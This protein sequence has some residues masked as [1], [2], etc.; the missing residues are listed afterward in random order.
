MKNKNVYFYWTFDHQ[1]KKG[2]IEIAYSEG[3]ILPT[4]QLIIIKITLQGI[5]LLLKYVI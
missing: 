4:L 1:K 3:S 2:I 5:N